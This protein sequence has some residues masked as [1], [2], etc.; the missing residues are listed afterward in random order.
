MKPHSIAKPKISQSILEVAGDF[1]RMGK[2]LEDRQ[3]R[4]NAA[5]SAWNMACNT[6]ELRKKHLDRYVRGYGEFNPD[7]DAE[8]L[9]NV[10]KDMEQLIDRKLKMFPNDLRQIVSARIVKAGA[11]ERIEAA[12]ATLQ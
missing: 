8:H 6:P 9:A 4:L 7:A 11:Q 3:N 5:C 2:T 1:I 10:R 12:A